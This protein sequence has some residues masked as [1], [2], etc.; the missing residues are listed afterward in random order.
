[1]PD[2]SQA[3]NGPVL[4]MRMLHIPE[5]IKVNSLSKHGLQISLLRVLDLV[6][7]TCFCRCQCLI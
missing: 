1:M 5:S 3:I 6:T 2:L 7:L 4:S